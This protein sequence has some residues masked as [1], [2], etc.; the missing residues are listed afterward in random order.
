MPLGSV[1]E[2]EPIGCVDRLDVHVEDVGIR[3]GFWVSGIS[4]HV[5]GGAVYCDRENRQIPV[6][7]IRF[8]LLLKHPGMGSTKPQAAQAWGLG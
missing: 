3:S 5:E 8:G 7:H 2:V 1:L 6:G 4:S